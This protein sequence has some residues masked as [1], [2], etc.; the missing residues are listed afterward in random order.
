MS[1][2]ERRLQLGTSCNYQERN[3][4]DLNWNVGTRLEGRRWVKEILKCRF[5][6]KQLIGMWGTCSKENKTII[7]GAQVSNPRKMVTALTETV[8]IEFV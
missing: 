5:Q 3:N 7:E 8:M 6:R 2:C 1:L 4:E